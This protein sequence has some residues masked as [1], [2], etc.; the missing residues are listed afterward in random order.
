MPL[1]PLPRISFANTALVP[2]SVYHVPGLTVIGA[3][4]LPAKVVT[5]VKVGHVT[6]VATDTVDG[7]DRVTAPV[8]ADAVMLFAV[9]AKEVT[10]LF[11]KVGLVA[12]PPIVIPVPAVAV[13]TPVFV[14]IG[15]DVVPVTEIPEP[16]VIDVTVPVATVAP[17]RPL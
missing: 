17:V 14:M 3:E 12:V 10:P 16:A 2:K 4:P 13:R 1:A 8:D 11:V 5:P 7:S 9:P 15:V 6:L